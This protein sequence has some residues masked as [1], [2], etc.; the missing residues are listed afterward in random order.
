[1]QDASDPQEE[2]EVLASLGIDELLE[3][4][5]DETTGV[6]DRRRC[7]RALRARSERRAQLA[8]VLLCFDLAQAGDETAQAEMV[9]LRPAFEEAVD[10]PAYLEDH[11][12]L[13]SLW[14]KATAL[15]ARTDPRD[16]APFFPFREDVGREI[17]LFSEADI[18]GEEEG[19]GGDEAHARARTRELRRLVSASLGQD[20][21]AHV[22]R[23]GSQLDLSTSDDVDRLEAFLDELNAWASMD[24]G[25]KALACIGHL[26]LG[27]HLRRKTVFGTQNPR[28]MKA[29]R[30]GLFALDSDPVL[31]DQAAAF[32]SFEG[33]GSE[34]FRKVLELLLDFFGY[35]L[36]RGVSPLEAD[37]I[38]DYSTEAR[39]P[40]M[41]L[42]TDERRRR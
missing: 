1:M 25:A 15:L 22:V 11:P 38:H 9:L 21:Q 6:E 3:R 10:A 24:P 30:T 31:I 4:A 39:L 34:G 8:A 5:F 7:M 41:V 40:A 23:L 14:E 33:D 18:L 27:V 16:T 32:F 37:V 29:V 20:L 19:L 2:L 35:C 26:Y 28:R 17:P 12:K 36:K 42:A 13:L